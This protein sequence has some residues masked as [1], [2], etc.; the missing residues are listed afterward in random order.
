MRSLNADSS[1]SIGIDI[2]GFFIDKYTNRK[3]LQ[4]SISQHPS[5]PNP[6]LYKTSYYQNTNTVAGPPYKQIKQTKT[7]T[8]ISPIK[9]GNLTLPTIPAIQTTIGNTFRN[10]IN[11][12]IVPKILRR[13]LV[14]E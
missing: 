5:L 1:N 4:N 8:N 7:P 13:N 9:V 3:N 2:T 10:L 11:K 14:E 6:N 12:P